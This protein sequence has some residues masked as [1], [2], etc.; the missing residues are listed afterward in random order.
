MIVGWG[1][2]AVYLRSD[3]PWDGDGAVYTLQALHG[4]LSERSLHAGY[5]APLAAW[6]GVG[7]PPS[8]FGWLWGPVAL[9]LVAMLGAQWLERSPRNPHLPP[10][11][12]RFGLA[13]LIAP[14][15]LL[16]A[17]AS[18]RAM[19]T[20]EVYGPLATLLLGAAVALGARRAVLAGG[21][22]A[23]AAATHPGAWALI[24]GLLVVAARDRR[25]AARAVAV[26][27]LGYGLVLGAL[28]PDWWTGGRGLLALPA[29]DQSPW[30]SLQGAWRLLARDLGPVAVVLL[31]GLAVMPA[32]VVGGLALLVLGGAV[33]LDRFSDNP[34]QLPALWLAAAAA[35]GV[36]RWIEDL[37]SDRLRRFAGPVLG[38]LLLLGVAEATTRHDA[39]VRAMDR[40]VEALVAGG[41][42][43]ADLAWR[44]EARLRLLCR[45]R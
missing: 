27:A 2:L 36:V 34:G 40:E 7:L 25:S 32:R 31:G 26:A 33:G 10:D 43:R 6:A 19:G 38:V 14:A 1:C 13:P 5:L 37:G 23:W 44:D 45:T 3:A 4:S 8:I 28:W 9:V 20:V 11:E 29:S 15:V 21:L 24:P 16:S 30:Q 41:C 12:A 18:W 35:P 39:A 22:L 17:T 42:D